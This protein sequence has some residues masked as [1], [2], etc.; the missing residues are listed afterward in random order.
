MWNIFGRLIEKSRNQPLAGEEEAL[1]EI[2][3]TQDRTRI[4]QGVLEMGRMTHKMLKQSLYVAETNNNEDAQTVI[5]QDN[6]VDRLE[7][8]IDWECLSTM[9]MRQPIHDDLRFLFAVI[10]LTT[11]LERIADESANIARHLL[12]HRSILQESGDITIIR[13]LRDF[14]L[15]QLEDVMRAFEEQ[16]LPLAQKVF[17]RDRFVDNCYH[18]LYESFLDTI[19]EKAS[20][21]IHRQAYILTLARH[22]ERAG[23]HIANV[24]EYIGFMITGERI[25]SEVAESNKE[26]SFNE[27]QA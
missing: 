15:G 17:T 1:D 12:L 19:S 27:P 18:K 20:A 8:V 4:T 23:D 22:L 13:S 7:M 11:D 16:N 5:D 25:T 6:D 14:L 21:E 10:K 9:A 26:V 2:L 3:M 24:A